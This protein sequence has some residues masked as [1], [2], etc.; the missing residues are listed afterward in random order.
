NGYAPVI[1]VRDPEGRPVLTGPVPFLPLDANL[2][3]TG[4]VKVPDGLADQV[5]IE[6]LFYPDPIAT[7][8]GAL[9]SF[10]PYERGQGL[11]TMAVYR[12]DLAL[13][14][15]YVLDTERMEQLAGRENPLVLR[16]GETAELPA[17]LGTVSFDGYVRYVSLDIR[18]DPARGW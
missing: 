14:N 17:G 13:G 9:A 12:G 7:P 5:G 18:H 4:V 1:T 8:S 3:S 10:S 11:I 2:L 15:V 16:V 6:A